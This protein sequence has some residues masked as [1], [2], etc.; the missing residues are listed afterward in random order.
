MAGY[1]LFGRP[2][3]G[4]AMIEAQLSALGLAFDYEEV[5]DLFSSEQGRRSLARYNPLAQVPTLQLPDGSVMT[6]SAAITLHLADATGRDDFVP[7]AGYPARPQFLRWLV[8]LV[9]NVYPT[10][11][12]GDD[13]QRFVRDET[14]AKAFSDALDDYRIRLWRVVEPAAGAPW[15]LGERFSALDIYVCVMTRWEPRRR[16]FDEHAPS[17]AA[18]A[19]RADEDARLRAVWK[20]NFPREFA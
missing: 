16:W 2:G 7:A 10:F 1:R 19:R 18:I 5:P 9:T 4:S 8:F 12:Y 14:A 11:T 20:H 17:L 15:F 3:W 13:P 6:E